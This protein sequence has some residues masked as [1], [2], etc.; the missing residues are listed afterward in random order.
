MAISHAG[1]EPTKL[2]LITDG[3][4]HENLFV[5]HLFGL[6]VVIL[7][8]IAGIV[9]TV[10]TPESGQRLLQRVLSFRPRGDH[11]A[12]VDHLVDL[13]RFRDIKRF[14][15]LPELHCEDEVCAGLGLI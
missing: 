3:K 6:L 15:L 5:L 10:V 14:L 11:V 13:V 2:T 8:V 12:Q 1:R 4:L 9:V 7:D